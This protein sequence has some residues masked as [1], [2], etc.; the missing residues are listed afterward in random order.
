MY[1]DYQEAEE[2]EDQTVEEEEFEEADDGR[3]VEE[4]EGQNGFPHVID[5]T[6]VLFS[7]DHDDSD[8]T[9]D[10]DTVQYEYQ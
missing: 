9:F 8:Y 6:G 5:E 7:P 1:N 4:E 2:D 3:R 10:N